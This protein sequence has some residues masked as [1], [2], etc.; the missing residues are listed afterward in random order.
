M[1]NAKFIMKLI[2]FLNLLTVPVVVGLAACSQPAPPVSAAKPDHDAIA[3]IRAAGT[4][5]DSAVEVQP[6]RDPALDGLLKQARELEAQ[7]KYDEAITAAQQALALATAA[8]D[9]LQFLA[10]LELERQ[11]YK[12]AAMLAQQSF[13]AGP[14][15]GSLCARNWQTLI[16]IRHLLNDA[17]GVDQAKQQLSVCRA[18]RP[19]RM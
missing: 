1:E 3:A 18:S 9:I 5:S 19:V 7:A 11:H 13:D 17:P 6:L 12:E 15:V 10:E 16:E 2:K 8:P 4:Q 14:K